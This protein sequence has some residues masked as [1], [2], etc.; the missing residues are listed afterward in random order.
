MALAQITYS[1][2]QTI[3]MDLSGLASNATFVAGRESNQIDNTTNRY[4]DAIV[5]GNV[6]VGT[7]P[8]VN[9]SIAVFVWGSDESLATKPIDVLDGVDSAETFTNV[10]VLYSSLKIAATATVTVGTSDIQMP[11]ASFSVAALFGG[12]LPKFWGLYVAQNTGAALRA[13]AVNTNS[14]SYVGVEYDIT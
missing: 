5:R 1:A 9:G 3:T 13:N 12:V 8:S 2:N 14:F 11:I 6:S 10:G 7:G 4:I